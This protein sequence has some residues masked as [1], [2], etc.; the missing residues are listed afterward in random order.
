MYK[1]IFKGYLVYILLTPCS[2]NIRRKADITL[3][4]VECWFALTKFIEEQYNQ[5]N[6]EVSGCRTSEG[7][8]LG[9]GNVDALRGAQRSE[10]V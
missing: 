6:S 10:H 3:T 8:S 2:I 1:S 5:S 4:P 7:P 9:K